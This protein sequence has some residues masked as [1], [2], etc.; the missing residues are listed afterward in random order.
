[1]SRK[2]APPRARRSG[3]P[4]SVVASHLD[5]AA[6]QAAARG[7]TA[8][9]AELCE[10]AAQLTPSDPGL[11][12]RRRIRSAGFYRLAGERE[13]TVAMLDELLREI[14]GGR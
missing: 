14:T 1:M 3:G 7:A 13:R 12:H 5:A 4:D 11:A 6:E 10:M 9:A 2:G 8:A